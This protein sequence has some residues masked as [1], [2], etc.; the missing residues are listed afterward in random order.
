[1]FLFRDSVY[2]GVLSIVQYYLYDIYFRVK[3]FNILTNRMFSSKRELEG[4]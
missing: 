3:T 2:F 1:M 4:I